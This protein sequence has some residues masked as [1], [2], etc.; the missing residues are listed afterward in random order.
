MEMVGV[1]RTDALEAKELMVPTGVRQSITNITFQQE[2]EHQELQDKEEAAAPVAV[3]AVDQ[4]F[5]VGV[6]SFSAQGTVVVVA[7]AVAKAVTPVQELRVEGLLLEPI[8][9]PTE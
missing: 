9:M 8:Y 4:L 1:D 6:R 2:Q 5:G 3:V 7:V